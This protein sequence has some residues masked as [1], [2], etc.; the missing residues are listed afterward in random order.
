MNGEALTI[1][2]VPLL[3]DSSLELHGGVAVLTFQRDDVRNA[4][5]GTALVDDLVRTVQWANTSTEVSVL[6][7]TGAG[8]AFSSG[9]NVKEMQEKSGIFA[10]GPIDV[11]NQYRR[12]IQQVPLALHKAEIPVIA[13]VNGPA[14][15]AGLDLACMCDIRIA[16]DKALI[17]GT[18]INLGIIPGDGG[19]WF[20]PRLVG[21]QRAAEMLFTGRIMKA[22]EALQLGL[23][24]EVVEPEEL[25][26]RARELAGQIAAKPPQALRLMKRLLKLAQRNDLPDFLDATACFQAMA[27][28][29]DD[30]LEAVTAFLEK[31]APRYSGR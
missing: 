23:F 19:A 27:H 12:G 4:L 21:Y 18:F 2:A 11:Q 30:H 6:V 28:H 24:L 29:S 3:Q 7:I 8:A 26:P 15:G 31:R 17:G 25:L 14:M 9:G 10:G 13:A 16:S 22:A 20:L 1:A 5:T